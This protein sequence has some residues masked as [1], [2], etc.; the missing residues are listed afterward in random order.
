L[1]LKKLVTDEDQRNTLM[2]IIN[3][4]LVELS[5]EKLWAYFTKEWGYLKSLNKIRE[6][7]DSRS[8]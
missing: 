6:K 8:D 5:E 2:A 3:T 4:E 1:E 7:N